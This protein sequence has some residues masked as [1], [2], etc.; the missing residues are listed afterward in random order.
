M[1]QMP[2]LDPAFLATCEI[3]RHLTQMPFYFAE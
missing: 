2:L 1:H 3:V